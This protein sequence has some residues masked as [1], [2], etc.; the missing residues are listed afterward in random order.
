MACIIEYSSTPYVGLTWKN[1]AAI[2][3][4][5]FVFAQKL[6]VWRVNGFHKRI[7]GHFDTPATRLSSLKTCPEKI[8]NT[9][10]ATYPCSKDFWRISFLINPFGTIMC[11][12]YILIPFLSSVYTPLIY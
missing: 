8:R 1:M 7:L 4:Y 10:S 9:N 3:S 5:K 12:F 11:Q 6:T 2:H